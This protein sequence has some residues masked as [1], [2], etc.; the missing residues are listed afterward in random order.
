MT[1]LGGKRVL[2]VDDSAVARDIACDALEDLG[3]TVV[4][5]PDIAALRAIED[6]AFD[7]VLMDVELPDAG[8]PDSVAVLR[9]VRAAARAVLLFSGLDEAEL[10]VRARAAHV[11][12]Y[13]SKRAGADTLV[14]E[15]SAW[16]D[17][18][19]VRAAEVAS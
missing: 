3:V 16:L 15:V 4:A 12:G 17:G 14:R 19:R 1:V 2:V 10:A 11:D 6:L 13:V 7:L 9:A 18:T 5:V 8:A